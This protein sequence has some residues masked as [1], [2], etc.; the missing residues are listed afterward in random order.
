MYTPP[1]TQLVDYLQR[2]YDRGMTTTSG[3][4]LS[5]L[6]SEGAIWITPSGIDKGSLR[7]SDVMKVLPDGTAIGPHRPSSELPFHRHIYQGRP[8]IRA[9]LH[10]HTPAIVAFSCVRRIPNIDAFPDARKNCGKV[11]FAPYAIPGSEALGD[12]IAAEIRNGA[13]CVVMENH[14]AVVCGTSIAQCFRRYEALV[15]AAEAELESAGLGPLLPKAPAPVP[16]RWP[17]FHPEEP[18]AMECELRASLAAFHSRCA[19][20]GIFHCGNS[21]AAARLG[22]D[23]FLA[24]PAGHDPLHVTPDAFV[25]VRSGARETGKI[26]AFPATFARE[27]F[28]TAP[29]AN[30]VYMAHPP[31]VTAF[32]ATG[33]PFDSRTIPESYILLRDV[34][35]VPAAEFLSDPAAAAARIT[36]RSP[37]LLIESLGIVTAGKSLLEG[38]DRLEVGEF[39]AKCCLLAQ[40]LGTLSPMTP[41]QVR[42]VVKAFKLPR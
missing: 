5:I 18:T 13:D 38:F 3:G 2:L 19:R 17:T 9:V 37:V 35:T 26:P 21:F 28:R 30:A 1:A 12:S 40:R 4:N 6:D 10:A 25:H 15:Q 16:A 33:A 41:A 22:D 11:A 24:T 34:A 14:G 42:A 36:P 27:V 29:W 8:G 31:H 39:T 32:A 7:P 20:Q 23:E